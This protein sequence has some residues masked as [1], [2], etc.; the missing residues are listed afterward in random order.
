MRL[1]LSP[2]GSRWY[3]S[4]RCAGWFVGFL[5]FNP[6]LVILVAMRYRELADR[7]YPMVGASI[8]FLALGANLVCLLGSLLPAYALQ[9]RTHERAP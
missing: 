9:V 6:A 7:F 4:G 1:G 3:C 5:F 2:S 8:V